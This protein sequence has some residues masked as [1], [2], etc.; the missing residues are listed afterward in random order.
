M[1]NTN[2]NSRYLLISVADATEAQ[3]GNTRINPH[4][5]AIT[6]EIVNPNY[7]APPTVDIDAI[8]LTW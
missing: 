7:I 5:G 6:I 2:T 1:N 3:K 8:E 4:T